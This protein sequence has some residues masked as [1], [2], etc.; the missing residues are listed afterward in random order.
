MGAKKIG[1]IAEGTTC[2][3]CEKIIEKQ[4]LKVK[5]VKS[6]EFDYSTE[7]GY[8]TYDDLETDIDTIL[9][10]IEEKGYQCFILEDNSTNSTQKYIEW[11]LGLI[12]I[13]A[14]VLF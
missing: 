13:F 4:V 14:G 12:A 9:F 2:E 11:I 10:K 1:F 3:S 5:G 7:T 6:V 8:V